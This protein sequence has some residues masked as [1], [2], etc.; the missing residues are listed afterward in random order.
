YVTSENKLYFSSDG[1]KGFGALDVFVADLDKGTEPM[2]VGLPVNSGQDDFAF[3]FN[4]TKNA[5]FF[6]SNRSGVDQLYSATPVCGVEAIVMVRDAK[7]GKALA[8]A[9]VSILD[10]KNNVIET[11]TAGADGRVVYNVDCNRAYSIQASM[12]KY[13]NGSF[14][15]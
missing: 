10:D 13:E 11:R 14:P 12:D 3:S 4:D 5:G 2:N 6:S 7:T 15:V 8:N 9:R 1:R